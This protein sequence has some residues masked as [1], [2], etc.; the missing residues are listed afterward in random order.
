MLSATALFELLAA[1]AALIAA[2]FIFDQHLARPRPYK[3]V[4]SLGLLCYGLGAA[5]GFAGSYHNWTVPEFTLWYVFGG[6]LTAVLLG[7]GSFYLLGPRRVAHALAVL[8]AVLSLYVAMRFLTSSLAPALATYIATHSTDT[9]AVNGKTALSMLPADVRAIT[10]P[11]NILG[12]LLL[13]GGAAWSAWTY[14]HKHAPGYRVISMALLA[15]GAL[16][17]SIGTGLQPL[18]YSAGAALGELLGALCLLTGLLI[19]LD[20]F[21]ILRVPFT[22]V[23]LYER[24]TAKA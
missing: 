11:L 4:W 22:P 24:R 14:L 6:T 19:S 12:A 16:F 23:V 2:V 18:G 1:I 8:V 20:V 7:L 21:T 13:F 3:L 5:A 9:S 10:I 15:L 17:P